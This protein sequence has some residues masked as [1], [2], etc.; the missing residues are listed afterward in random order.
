LRSFLNERLRTP[1]ATRGT[2]KE[3]DKSRKKPER[4]PQS[5]HLL[6]Q[7]KVS[8]RHTLYDPIRE[9][10]GYM[11]SIAS[12]TIM[13]ADLKSEDL[14]QLPSA[15]EHNGERLRMAFK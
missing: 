10:S 6:A 2:D 11:Q 5:G 9:L 13:H 7:T 4:E 1:R 3:T 15:V 12:A 14:F 8:I